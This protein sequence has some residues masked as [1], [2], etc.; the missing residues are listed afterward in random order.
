MVLQNS[1]DFSNILA[2]YSE[3]LGY[4]N[5]SQQKAI[6]ILQNEGF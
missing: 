5:F 4:H 6:N 2:E 1:T 3:N